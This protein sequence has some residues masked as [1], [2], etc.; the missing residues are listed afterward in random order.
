VL[1]TF[2]SRKVS[3]DAT[4]LTETP[5]SALRWR[6]DYRRRFGPVAMIHRADLLEVLRAAV[7]R[8]SLRHGVAVRGAAPDG[9]VTHDR[10]ESRADLIVG[11]DGIRSTVRAAV[12]PDAPAPRYAGYTAWRMVTPPVRVDGSSE[13]WGS[14]ERFGYAPLPD[15]RVYCFA[16]ANAREGDPGQGWLG[17][18]PGSAAGTARSRRCWTRPPRMPCCTMTCTNC[19][20]PA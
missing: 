5:A 10:G 11:A 14:G 17:C 8:Q 9:T 13:S 1:I 16:V 12:W 2:P 4:S 15:G 18:V 7:P 3:R 6:A 20:A 19:R